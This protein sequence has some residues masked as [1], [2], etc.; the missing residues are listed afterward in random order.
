M[1][2]KGVKDIKLIFLHHI[3]LI[4]SVILISYAAA[5]ESC[6]FLLFSTC[7]MWSI[8]SRI[9]IS[10]SVTFGLQRF[11][12]V[13]ISLNQPGFWWGPWSGWRVIGLVILHRSR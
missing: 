13:P 5:P 8:L 6:T 3:S 12:V 10:R 9:A 7:L 1:L 2:S 11:E 4:R